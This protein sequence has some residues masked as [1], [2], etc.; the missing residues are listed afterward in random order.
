MKLKDL[1]QWE[2]PTVPAYGA[3]S[4]PNFWIVK[5][6]SANYSYK[7]IV[8]RRWVEEYEPNLGVRVPKDSAKQGSATLEVGIA[9]AV[10]R[11]NKCFRCVFQPPKD[12]PQFTAKQNVDKSG[13]IT[14]MNKT[15]GEDLWLLMGMPEKANK[16]YFT[17]EVEKEVQG[18]N[19]YKAWYDAKSGQNL[20][21][22]LAFSK[23]KK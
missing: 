16:Q 19:V 3:T 6:Q 18:R 9:V 2:I 13:T 23:N 20:N 8:N 4:S 22:L 15:L 7:L 11:E 14:I 17:F 10:D 5:S 12:V 1:L 21:A